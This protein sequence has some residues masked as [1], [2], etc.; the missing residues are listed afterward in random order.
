MEDKNGCKAA[1][2]GQVVKIPVTGLAISRPL[3]G[4]CETR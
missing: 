4:I 1:G 2:P 3:P